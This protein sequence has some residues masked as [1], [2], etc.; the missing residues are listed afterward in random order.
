MWKR[1]AKRILPETLH[2]EFRMELKLATTLRAAREVVTTRLTAG[3][4]VALAFLSGVF[5]SYLASFEIVM[6]ETFD[7]ADAFPYI[8]G[9]L[10]IVTAL[11][12]FA[13]GVLVERMGTTMLSHVVMTGSWVTSLVLLLLALATGGTPAF[14]AYVVVIGVLL[15]FQAF[16]QV[17]LGPATRQLDRRGRAH[18]PAASAKR[19][20]NPGYD[21]AIA[22]AFSMVTGAL[23]GAILDQAFDGTVT[24]FAVGAAIYSTCALAAIWWAE[25]G[26][27][28]SGA[29]KG[30]VTV[31]DAP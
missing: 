15:A 29:A 13:N 30:E 21:T 22:S 14:A 16:A 20:A 5:F 9:A 18:C 27:M 11:A 7:L 17:H 23:L 26:R 10:A 12:L 31:P 6:T 8:F 4:A 1:L 3:Y 25:R 28:F 24:P 2:P 19:S